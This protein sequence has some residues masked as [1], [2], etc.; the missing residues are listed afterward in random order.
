MAALTDVHHINR[1]LL[2]IAKRSKTVIRLA[3][4]K[5]WR[6]DRPPP[7]DHDQKGRIAQ[8]YQRRGTAL[9]RQRTANEEL[10][11]DA[12]AVLYEARRGMERHEIAAALD[13]PPEERKRFY[14]MLR[15]HLRAKEENQR[16]RLVDGKYEIIRIVGK[17]S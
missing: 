9:S 16:F 2:E 8:G 17:K 10:M 7:P 5:W 12:V 14:E 1:D 6:C 3:N 4:G 13:I 11:N 15:N